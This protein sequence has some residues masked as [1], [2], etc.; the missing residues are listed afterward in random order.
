MD[1]S[2]SVDLCILRNLGLTP[3]L[4]MNRSPNAKHEWEI[5]GVK[6]TSNQ[7]QERNQNLSV[8]TQVKVEKMRRSSQNNWVPGNLE[9]NC[10]ESQERRNVY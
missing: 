1:H 4:Q 10:R 7:S 6:V 9:S 5:V 3:A 2:Q 8:S